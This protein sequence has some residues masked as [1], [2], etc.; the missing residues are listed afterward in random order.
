MHSKEQHYGRLL[1]Y[2][3]RELNPSC[4]VAQ[5]NQSRVESQ[6]L[7]LLPIWNLAKEVLLVGSTW[8]KSRQR[9]GGWGEQMNSRVLNPPSDTKTSKDTWSDALRVSMASVSFLFSLRVSHMKKR[10]KRRRRRNKA[11]KGFIYRGHICQASNPTQIWELCIKLSSKLS[12]LKSA[13]YLK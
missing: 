13:T 7:P 4:D 10:K 8:K 2:S 12:T 1:K 5:Q 11:R 3:A 9:K 6:L